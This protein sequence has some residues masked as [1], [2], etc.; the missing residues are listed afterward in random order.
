MPKIRTMIG[1]AK[2]ATTL[3]NTTIGSQE[4]HREDNYILP[5]MVLGAPPERRLSREDLILIS[6]CSR[7]HAILKKT[8]QIPKRKM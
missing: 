7:C 6:G 5:L 2:L 4:I 1:R 8:M 3:T